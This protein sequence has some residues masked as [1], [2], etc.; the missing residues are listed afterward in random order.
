MEGP[1]IYFPNWFRKKREGGQQSPQNQ[2]KSCGAQGIN[3]SN[4]QTDNQKAFKN[5]NNYD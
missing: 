3:N 1:G 5:N 2:E 4:K